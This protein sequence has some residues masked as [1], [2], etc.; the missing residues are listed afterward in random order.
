MTECKLKKNEILLPDTE[1]K[2]IYFKGL[3][4]NEIQ[5]RYKF[6]FRVLIS[7]NSFHNKYKIISSVIISPMNIFFD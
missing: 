7:V 5:A 1:I 3:K 6:I 2:N 4:R